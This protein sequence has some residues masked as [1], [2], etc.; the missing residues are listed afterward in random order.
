MNPTLKKTTH[1][2]IFWDEAHHFA[3]QIGSSSPGGAQLCAAALQRL[4]GSGRGRRVGRRRQQRGRCGAAE[5]AAGAWATEV[6]WE[7]AEPRMRFLW[8][9]LDIV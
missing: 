8:I 1:T 3:S 2:H 9:S 7:G 4:G 6:T 5:D